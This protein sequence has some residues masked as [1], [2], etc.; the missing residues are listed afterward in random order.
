MSRLRCLLFGHPG[1]R[2]TTIVIPAGSLGQQYSIRYGSAP[3]EI[4][5]SIMHGRAWRCVRCH[6][7]RVTDVDRRRTPRYE[8]VSEGSD[9]T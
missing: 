4:E 3:A 2:E 8:S 7:G 9:R 6:A 1:W 5:A